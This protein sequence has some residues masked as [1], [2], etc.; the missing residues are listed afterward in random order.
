MIGPTTTGRPIQDI[1]IAAT[2]LPGE[3]PHVPYRY[4]TLVYS[5]TYVPALNTETESRAWNDKMYFRPISRDEMNRN[6]LLVNNPG[7]EE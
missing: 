6:D 5:Y 4:D 1:N 2:L 7:H 3:T